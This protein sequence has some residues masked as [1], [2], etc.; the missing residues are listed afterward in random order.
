M[1]VTVKK[2]DLEKFIADQLHCGLFDSAD[3]LVEA[4]VHRMMREDRGEDDAFDA[5]TI[6]AI[7]RGKE[8]IERGEG[9]ELADAAAQ[10][11]KRMREM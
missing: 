5:E 1:Q 3:E 8:Q 6:A 10:L 2:P 4:A 11:R 9:I 7:L